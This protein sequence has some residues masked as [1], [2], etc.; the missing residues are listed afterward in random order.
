VETARAAV[1]IKIKTRT[2]CMEK[3]SLATCYHTS[4][5]PTQ[6]YQKAYVRNGPKA[7][8]SRYRR[9][10]VEGRPSADFDA[11]ILA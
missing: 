6:A 1:P 11:T 8:L 5:T 7:D 10:R 4:N 2:V 3:S 9:K